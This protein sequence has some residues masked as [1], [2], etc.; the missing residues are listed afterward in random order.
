[1]I[2][3]RYLRKVVSAPK[4]CKNRNDDGW[5]NKLAKERPFKHR[6]WANYINM[7]KAR[8][9][10]PEIKKI[11]LG[12]KWLGWNKGLQNSSMKNTRLKLCDRIGKC[13]TVYAEVFTTFIDSVICEL[14]MHVHVQHLFSVS[15]QLLWIC[16]NY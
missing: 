6:K 2:A 10:V 4:Q 16:Q 1:M 7:Y 9:L 15:T 13:N 8:Y 12:F 3:M 11:S 5:L 14:V